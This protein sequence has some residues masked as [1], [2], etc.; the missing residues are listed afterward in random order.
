MDPWVEYRALLKLT[1]YPV[2]GQFQMGG[3][4]ASSNLEKLP[5]VSQKQANVGHRRKLNHY[6]LP[7]RLIYAIS[8]ARAMRTQTNTLMSE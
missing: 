4:W 8:A 5:H 1:H 6:S 3:T 2:V 7:A